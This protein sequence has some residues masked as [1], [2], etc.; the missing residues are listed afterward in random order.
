MSGIPLQIERLSFPVNEAYPTD[1]SLQ[2]SDDLSLAMILHERGLLYL[3]TYHFSIAAASGNT[4]AIILYAMS[5]RS[6]WGVTA[7]PSVAYTL[8]EG[9]ANVISTEICRGSGTFDTIRMNQR[10]A[11]EELAL[12]LHEL[13]I[14]YKE[15]WGVKKSKAFAVYFM[16]LSARLDDKDAQYELGEMYMRGEGVPKNKKL[17]AKWYRKAE[18]NGTRMVNMQWIWKEVNQH[19]NT[20]SFNY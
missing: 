15:G 20:N 1:I 11:K 6:G 19:F 8:L 16:F 7:N 9:V 14:S 5:L 17:A 2:E 13:A 4:L 12:A 18:K 10:I 3:S